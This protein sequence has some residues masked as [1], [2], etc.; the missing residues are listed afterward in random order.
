[1]ALAPLYPVIAVGTDVGRPVANTLGA[2][3]Q[4]L[5]TGWFA[6]SAEHSRRRC[7]TRYGDVSEPR[8]RNPVGRSRPI[9]ARRRISATL[10][11]LDAAP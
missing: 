7:L 3:G 5:I 4:I 2:A 8:R 10:A 6:A 9:P 1:M 11:H